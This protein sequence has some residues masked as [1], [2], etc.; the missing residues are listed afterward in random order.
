MKSR[1]WRVSLLVFCL[2]AAS[3]RFPGLF[4]SSFHADEAL[5]AT[6]ARLIAVWRD[7][8]LLTQAIDK[9]PLLFYLQ[10]LFYP[11][12]GPME[13]AARMPSLIASVLLVPLTAQLARRLTADIRAAVVAALIVTVA[14]LTIQFSATGFTDPLLM[15][16]LVAALYCVAGPNRFRA[17]LF[18]GLALATKYQAI[19]FAPLLLGVIWLKDQSNYRAEVKAY[20]PGRSYF[21]FLAGFLTILTALVV[22]QAARPEAGGLVPLQWANIGGLRLARS[23]E[24]AGRLAGQGQLWSVMLGWPMIGLAVVSGFGLIMIQRRKSVDSLRLTNADFLLLLFVLGYLSFHWLWAIPV[25]DRYFLPVFPLLA[26]L[27]GRA[28]SLL[29]AATDWLFATRMFLSLVLITLLIAQLSVA[30]E[31][32]AGLF[33]IGGQPG[34]DGGASNTARL[35]EDAPYGTVLYDHWYSWH[36]RYQLFD[37]RVYVSWFSDADAL[38]ADLAVFAG[39]GSPRYI[40][41]PSSSLAWP[42]IRRLTEDGYQLDPVDSQSGLADMILYRIV[43]EK[44]DD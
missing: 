20:R 31:A 12:F 5:F 1:P 26:I 7:P 44:V 40:A 4:A 17:G 2:L 10:A 8:L 11:L 43:P 29:W 9:P 19:L 42:V 38:L 30:A 3:L 24:L 22:W 14:P 37:S 28:V 36:W 34:A 13:W 23:W 39:Q 21:T 27:I 25:W 15:F 41:L 33:P 35:L 6:W 32:R 18:F 16:W